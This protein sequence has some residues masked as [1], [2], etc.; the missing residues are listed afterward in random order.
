MAPVADRINL[1][2]KAC[3]CVSSSGESKIL[4]S[5]FRDALKAQKKIQTEKNVS[6]SIYACPEKRGFHLTHKQGDRG[7]SYMSTESCSSSGAAKPV[8]KST[9]AK[10]KSV[11]GFLR[12]LFSK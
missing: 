10:K 2:K 8:K 6:L 9:S 11:F 3:G 4:Y 7:M 1:A 5:T 12:K